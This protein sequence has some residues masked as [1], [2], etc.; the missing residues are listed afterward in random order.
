M[1]F[2]ERLQI[3]LE[4]LEP[5]TSEC[6]FVDENAETYLKNTERHL[7]KVAAPSLNLKKG[8]VLGPRELGAVLGHKVA[9]VK[10]VG[11]GVKLLQGPAANVVVQGPGAKELDELRAVIKEAESAL[12][13]E[14][15]NCVM[16]TMRRCVAIASQQSMEEMRQFF[17]GMNKAL[18]VG[19]FTREGTVAGATTVT[20]FYLFLLTIGSQLKEHVKSMAQL[21]QV[22]R[23]LWGQRAGD[24][25]TTEKRCKRIGL[26]FAR[27]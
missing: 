1:T 5:E 9:A 7:A 19:T 12:G 2:C 11:E 8:M 24:I 13:G 20:E 10:A 18:A 16:R 17:V 6:G 4:N 3:E 26:S 23:S 22:C 14:Y 27:L 21:H 15:R 25:K